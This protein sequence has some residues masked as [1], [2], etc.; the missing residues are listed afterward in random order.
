MQ[1]TTT[2]YTQPSKAQHPLSIFLKLNKK[3]KN[4][5]T[6]EHV[7]QHYLITAMLDEYSSVRLVLT[8]HRL[9]FKSYILLQMLRPKRQRNILKNN[10]LYGLLSIFHFLFLLNTTCSIWFSVFYFQSFYSSIFGCTQ[11]MRLIQHKP[12][13][14]IT[15]F[16]SS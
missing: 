8:E 5:T 4:S 11:N 2:Q 7:S 15:G 14:S 3:N 12:L 6:F 1:L 9:I 10:G 16:V 13:Y